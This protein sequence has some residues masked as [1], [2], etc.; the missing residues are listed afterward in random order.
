MISC[1]FLSLKK[2]EKKREINEST[3]QIIAMHQMF[4]S[5][6]VGLGLLFSKGI[7][8]S[9]IWC[10]MIYQFISKKL[11]K[12]SK[13]LSLWCFFFHKW[14]ISFILKSGNIVREC[15]LKEVRW[16]SQKEIN[17]VFLWQSENLHIEMCRKDINKAKHVILTEWMNS[18]QKG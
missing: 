12:I 7:I 16:C 14:K 5:I 8:L 3:N 13:Y 1:S 18:E 2:K 10:S 17:V 11:W 15:G 4:S 9:R 6:L